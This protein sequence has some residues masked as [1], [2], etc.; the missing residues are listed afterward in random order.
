MGETFLYTYSNTQNYNR[1][2]NKTSQKLFYNNFI[3]LNYDKN[4]RPYDLLLY[5]IYNFPID[6]QQINI[7]VIL[8]T[9]TRR[10]L[11]SIELL[12]VRSQVF[13]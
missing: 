2:G 11:T 3:L 7:S 13:K 5:T 8:G 1:S 9:L 4:S 12:V 10:R 6:Y